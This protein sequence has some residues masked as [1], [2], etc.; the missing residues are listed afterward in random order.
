MTAHVLYSIWSPTD[1]TTWSDLREVLMRML[2]EQHTKSIC[3]GQKRF[4]RKWVKEKKDFHLQVSRRLTKSSQEPAHLMHRGVFFNQTSRGNEMAPL[5]VLW[6]WFTTANWVFLRRHA[7]WTRF[8][9][10][11]HTKKKRFNHSI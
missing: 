11:S 5:M 10:Y 2:Q 3:C 9:F 6:V 8:V 1:A 4:L 7:W